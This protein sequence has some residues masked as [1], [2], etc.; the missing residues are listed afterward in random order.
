MT[1][2]LQRAKMSRASFQL[3]AAFYLISRPHR[4]RDGTHSAPP[5]HSTRYCIWPFLGIPISRINRL[6][7]CS[8]LG[9]TA[10]ADYSSGHLHRQT[11][12]YPLLRG[13]KR[14]LRMFFARFQM[15]S[16]EL[17]CKFIREEAKTSL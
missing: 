13:P 9:L 7:L 11:G 16:C 14:F 8:A 17:L 12:L 6:L 1:E 15:P 10:S 3:R 5:Y 2:E 4:H